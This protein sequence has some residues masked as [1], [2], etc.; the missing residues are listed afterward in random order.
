MFFVYS[1]FRLL[2]DWGWGT[3]LTACTP[4]CTF[5]GVL[6]QWWVSEYMRQKQ[7][8]A[9]LFLSPPAPLIT[10]LP[11]LFLGDCFTF[12]WGSKFHPFSNIRQPLGSKCWASTVFGGGFKQLEETV[13]LS[14]A[15][16]GSPITSLNCVFPR[17][18]R[19]FLCHSE[20]IF[21]KL[22]VA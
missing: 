5:P 10:V 17:F 15:Q 7:F 9:M 18:K 8:S 19:Q 4:L 20:E 2:V 22:F 1:L 12:R 6:T 3:H 16:L 11:F 21:K 13:L 14:E